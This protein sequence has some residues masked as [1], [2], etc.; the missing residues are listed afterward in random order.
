LSLFLEHDFVASENLCSEQTSQEF[1]NPA[2]ADLQ[3][4]NCVEISKKKIW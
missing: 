2:F 3:Q 1:L 4:E